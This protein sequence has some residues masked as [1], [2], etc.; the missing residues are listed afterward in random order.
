M[1]VRTD[2]Q[3]SSE[4]RAKLP[5]SAKQWKHSQGSPLLHTPKRGSGDTPKGLRVP[6]CSGRAFLLCGLVASIRLSELWNDISI[7][8]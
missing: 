2:L 7:K 8:G 3:G 1:E 6:V 5:W 4:F